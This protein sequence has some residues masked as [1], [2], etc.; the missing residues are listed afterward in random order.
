MQALEDML[1]KERALNEQRDN[2]QQGGHRSDIQ[3]SWTSSTPITTATAVTNG[4]ARHPTA[5]SLDAAT[6]M[7]DLRE[8]ID[9]PDSMLNNRSVSELHGTLQRCCALRTDYI[10]GLQHHNHHQFQATI[11][12]PMICSMANCAAR[13]VQHCPESS[14]PPQKAAP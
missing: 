9:M 3:D 4:D 2:E 13:N 11:Q 8:S 7:V 12:N 10:S 6:A 1:L 14:S 5:L